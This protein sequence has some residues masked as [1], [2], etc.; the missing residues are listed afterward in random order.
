MVPLTTVLPSFWEEGVW[1][2][3][4]ASLPSLA[5]RTAAGLAARIGMGEERAAG[6]LLREAGV[7]RDDASVLAARGAW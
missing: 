4:E 7:R 2:R 6:Q 3:Q 1:L 5:R